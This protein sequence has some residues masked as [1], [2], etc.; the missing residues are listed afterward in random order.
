MERS[1]A[2]LMHCLCFL[3]FALP[4]NFFSHLLVAAARSP[5]LLGRADTASGVV[6]V[7]ET[8]YRTRSPEVSGET[9]VSSGGL[10]VNWSKAS[11]E[12]D[13]NVPQCPK[14]DPTKMP[15]TSPGCTGMSAG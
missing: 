13:V 9:G 12:L 10:P 6:T 7:A 8:G 4:L 11:P 5:V 15:M 1:L 3:A 2:C 14:G